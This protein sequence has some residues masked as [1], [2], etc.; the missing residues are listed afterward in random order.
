LAAVPVFAL[1]LLVFW[2]FGDR[3]MRGLGLRTE[4]A[5]ER[6][7]LSVTVALGTVT[8]AVFG[9]AVAGLVTGVS[10]LLLAAGMAA[11]SLPDLRA[12]LRTLKDGVRSVAWSRVLW[13]GRGWQS[14]AAW[15][16]G[17]IVV[18]GAVQALAP[19]TGMDTG[20][21]HFAAVK[22]MVREHGL[23]PAPD[24]W[25]H[26]TG[27]YYM[28]YLFGMALGGEG[29]ARLFSFL[30]SPLALLL[31]G[32]SSERLR[33]GTARAA[34]SVVALSPLFT[35]FTGYQYLELSVLLYLAGAFLAFHRYRTEGARGWAVLSASLAGFALGVKITA[36]PILVFIIPLVLAAVRRE[37]RRAWGLI[38]C[39][40]IAFC[41]PAGF[42]PTWNWSTTGSFVQGYLQQ[43]VED[44]AAAA[45]PDESRW[46]GQLVVALGSVV[47]TSEYWIDSAG[48]FVIVA[49]AGVLL[50]RK[51]AEARLPATLVLSAV[52]FYMFV[53]VVRLRSYLW[54]DGHARYL[55]PSLLGFGALAAAPFLSWMESCPK[56]VRTALVAGLLLPAL[57]LIA[58]KA[59]K[60][61]VAAPVV[62]GLESRSHYLAK[63]IETYEACEILNSLPDPNVRVLFLA[64]R[65]Y[66]LD[67]PGPPYWVTTG[68]RGREDLIRRVREAGVTHVLYE[69]AA[70]L[71]PWLK[72][73][74]ATFGTHPFVELRRWPWKQSGFVRLYAVEKP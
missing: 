10:C 36:F 27:G 54:I 24:D 61:A 18:L 5:V 13:P 21:F 41:V 15:L 58:L 62:L 46:L 45:G 8:L 67:R 19:V 63:K 26:R 25:F 22:I 40:A 55:G 56:K 29:L 37:G 9:L 34:A 7:A 30:A 4:S 60:A 12:N 28:I 2:S 68:V 73:P 35:G 47:T 1:L 64:Q 11:V 57:P 31:T 66:Y 17:I 48:P 59:G 3:V 20:K 51:P 70:Y 52:A 32:A 74:D 69:P 39:G 50:F 38:L 23:L 33:P 71:L 14:W 49:L 6:F 53:L 16:S 42:W 43:P 44:A 65:S 72:D